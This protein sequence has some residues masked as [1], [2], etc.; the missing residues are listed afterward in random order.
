MHIGL[1]GGTFNPIHNG[2]LYIAEAVREKFHLDRI[3]FIPS[4]TPPHKKEEE[5]PP[6]RHRLEMTRLALVDRPH[7]EL[8]EMEVKRAGKS[9]SVETVSELKR[10]YPRDRLF[11][12]IGTDAFF[13]LPTW[14]EPERLLSLCDFVVV[15]RPGHPFSQLPSLGPLQKIDL[16]SLMELERRKEGIVTFP[17]T[18]ETS[19]HFISLPPSPISASE[20]RKKLAAGE[21][22]KNLL[23]DPVASYI[24]K[25]KI[26]RTS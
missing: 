10:F 22:T 4:G 6:A 20:I 8:C 23:P 12:I 13:D 7:F 18:S 15:T 3:L 17:V 1:L 2:H 25:N 26:Y 19:L 24:I 21:D 16:K 11:F 5:I 14:R 9:Y